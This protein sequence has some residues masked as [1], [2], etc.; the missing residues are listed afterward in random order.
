[1]TGWLDSVLWLS[2]ARLLKRKA[3]Q[4]VHRG[5]PVG[6]SRKG[7]THT[8]I[9]LRHSM[10]VGKITVGRLTLT[11]VSWMPDGGRQMAVC[12]GAGRYLRKAIA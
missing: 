12:H 1:V 11:R 6:A 2:R 9:V 8:T 4:G 10:A 7:D 3:I 5:I